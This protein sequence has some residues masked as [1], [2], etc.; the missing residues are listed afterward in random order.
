VLQSEVEERLV[1]RFLE[2]FGYTPVAS[3]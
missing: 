2:V 3:R 1:A